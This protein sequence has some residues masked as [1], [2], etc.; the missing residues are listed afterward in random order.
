MKV[1]AVTEKE[2]QTQVLDLA[3]LSGWLEIEKVLARR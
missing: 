1:G 2:F 3:R